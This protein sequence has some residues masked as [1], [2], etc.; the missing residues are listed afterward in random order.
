M[1]V[2]IAVHDSAPGLQPQSR[3]RLFEAF[4]TAKPHVLG[5]GPAIS[6]SIVEAHGG[7]L[8][9]TANTP[10]GAVFQFTLPIDKGRVP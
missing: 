8:S 1:D 5:M 3:D 2:L 7:R 6:R 10:H 4:Y 9:A